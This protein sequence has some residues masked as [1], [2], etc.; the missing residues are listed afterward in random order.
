MNLRSGK[1]YQPRFVSSQNITYEIIHENDFDYDYDNWSK[2]ISYL[3]TNIVNYSVQINRNYEN[4]ENDLTEKERCNEIVRVFR[5]IYYLV[6]Y[7]DIKSIPRLQ[8]FILALK[9]KAESSII[10]LNEILNRN[11]NTKGFRLTGK[12]RESA[13]YLIK[14]LHDFLQS[15]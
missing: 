4:H 9:K 2:S 6:D 11:G 15:F 5:E 10:E 8:K 12:D 1:R 14:E 7:Y 3:I 13:E